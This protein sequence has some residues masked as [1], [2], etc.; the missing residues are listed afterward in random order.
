[1]LCVRVIKQFPCDC[2]VCANSSLLSSIVLNPFSLV[3]HNAIASSA[4]LSS[5]LLRVCMQSLSHV[6]VDSFS[7][8]VYHTPVYIFGLHS[9]CTGKNGFLEWTFIR[10]YRNL[11]CVFSYGKCFITILTGSLH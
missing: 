3:G 5:H 1:M 7:A 10:I 9:F 2:L 4:P 11:N 8:H 6:I